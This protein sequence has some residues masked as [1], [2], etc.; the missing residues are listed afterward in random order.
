MREKKE[1][2]ERKKTKK[3][4]ETTQQTQREREERLGTAVGRFEEEERKDM[5]RRSDFREKRKKE[6]GT[7]RTEARVTA[8]QRRKE[9]GLR[10]GMNEQTSRD[11]P[12]REPRPRRRVARE[13]QPGVG[14]LS[15]PLPTAWP[16]N[17]TRPEVEEKENGKGLGQKGGHPL[18]LLSCLLLLLLL[19]LFER[20]RKERTLA[21]ASI[22]RKKKR[23]RRT[24]LLMTK[25][26]SFFSSS[27]PPAFLPV[28]FSSSFPLF[29]LSTRLYLSLSRG[30]FL[31]FF[32]LPSIRTWGSRSFQ[33]PSF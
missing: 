12:S 14:S 31:F 29:S 26:S 25:L 8:K 27:S 30:V 1:E 9:R 11:Q 4:E 33:H 10:R 5:Q 22:L 15:S 17:T 7:T 3:K 16:H 18:A 24:R 19:H 23:K 32:F 13:R 6:N 21:R 28:G 2:R 20:P